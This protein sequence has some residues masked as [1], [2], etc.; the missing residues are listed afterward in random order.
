MDDLNKKKMD[1]SYLGKIKVA[2]IENKPYVYKTDSGILT[3]LDYTL[4][5]QLQEIYNFDF[6]YDYISVEHLN[7]KKWTFDKFLSELSNSDYTFAV[8][9]IQQNEK[10]VMKVNFTQPILIDSLVVLY[11]KN[12]SKNSLWSFNNFTDVYV[13]VSPDFY[14]TI[15]RVI[16][17]IFIMSIIFSLIFYLTLKKSRNH[18]FYVS[19]WRV[20][21]VMFGEFSYIADIKYLSKEKYLSLIIRLLIVMVSFFVGIIIMALFTSEA[22]VKNINFNPYDEYEDLSTKTVG[23]AKG[24]NPAEQLKNTSKKFNFKIVEIPFNKSSVNTVVTAIEKN[25]DLDIVILPRE[26]Y[27]AS[28]YYHSHILDPGSIELDRVYV[29]WA[30]NVNKVECYHIINTVLIHYRDT[31]QTFE[32]CKQFVDNP[33]ESC[34]L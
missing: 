4:L 27:H 32:V 8:G 19:F 34:D 23:V 31:G 26:E 29:S 12:E 14:A 25:K 11:N 7:K 9:G 15:L 21:A 13:N 30:F 5:K 17:I 16:L 10:R 18:S 6:E 22:V 33:I 1:Y 24:T 3:G 20:A 2:L 28:K